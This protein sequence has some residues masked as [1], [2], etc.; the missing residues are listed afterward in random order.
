MTNKSKMSRWLTVAF[1]ITFILPLMS[2][3]TAQK[4]SEERKAKQ[5]LTNSGSNSRR[6]TFTADDGL[7]HVG[8]FYPV[9]EKKGPAVILIHMIEGSRKDWAIAAED[10]QKNGY[11]VLTYD[12]RGFGESIT[13]QDSKKL[14]WET[15]TEADY[16]KMIKDVG[17]A[18]DFLTGH[19]GVNEKRIGIIGADLGANIGLNYAVMNDQNIKTII[20]VSANFNYKGIKSRDAVVAYGKRPVMFCCSK[21]D[22]PATHSTRILHEIALGQKKLKYY[23]SGSGHGTELLNSSAEFMEDITQWLK[24]TL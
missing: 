18:L 10:L 1:C 19:A 11:A 15:F 21:K 23:P 16:Q 14:N 5:K 7:I 9:K 3:A 6:I 17:S 13:T 20:C 2:Y 22:L 24:E 12:L 8:T 4:K